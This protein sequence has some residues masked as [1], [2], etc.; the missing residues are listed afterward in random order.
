M[1]VYTERENLR[2][3]NDMVLSGGITSNTFG[4]SNIE[5]CYSSSEILSVGNQDEA[6]QRIGGI[7]GEHSG[8]D[9]SYCYNIGNLSTQGIGR[10]HLGGIIGY[11]EGN[12]NNSYN[13]GSITS[14]LETTRDDFLGEIIGLTSST[15][16]IKNCGYNAE[17]QNSGI[18]VNNG[19]GDPSE[20]LEMPE[21]ISVIGDEFK[22]ISGVILLKWQ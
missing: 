14:N 4:T 20:L 21:I 8:K 3:G 22:N 19:T 15:S 2:A 6:T 18:G 17:S 12:I 16:I 10:S 11:S 7:V 9:I 13:N 5:K 1:G